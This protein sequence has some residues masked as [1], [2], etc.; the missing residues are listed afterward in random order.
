MV[1]CAHDAARRAADEAGVPLF[2][3][4]RID[5]HRMPSGDRAAWL[6]ETLARARAYAAAGADGI[7]VLGDLD[8]QTVRTLVDG[9]PLP[10]NLVRAGVAVGSGYFHS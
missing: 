2:I 4:A 3:N 1:E 10:V 7:F 8:A 9:S 6:E 5:T